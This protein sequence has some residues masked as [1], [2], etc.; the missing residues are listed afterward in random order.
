[1]RLFNRRTELGLN[2]LQHMYLNKGTKSIVSAADLAQ[3]LMESELFISDVLSVL[4]KSGFVYS[5]RGSQG[6]YVLH[7]G[8]E[9]KPLVA[10]LGT[11]DVTL[12]SNP[13]QPKEAASEVLDGI[14]T[15]LLTEYKLVDVFSSKRVPPPIF[16]ITR[17]EAGGGSVA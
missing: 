15:T 5:L 4:R 2:I 3:T 14:L 6:G 17:A 16:R 13:M 11:F 12:G 10:F 8:V 1:M 7:P 9:T